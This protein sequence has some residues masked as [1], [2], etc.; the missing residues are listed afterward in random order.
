MMRDLL[1]LVMKKKSRKGN[2]KSL[3]VFL[4][5]TGISC[6]RLNCARVTWLTTWVF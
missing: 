6:K 2:L 1:R 3:E 4:L 5:L